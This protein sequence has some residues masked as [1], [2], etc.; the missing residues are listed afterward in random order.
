MLTPRLGVH[1]CDAGRPPSH[2]TRGVPRTIHFLLDGGVQIRELRGY[3]TKDDLKRELQ[4]FA[5]KDDLNDLRRTMLAL[6]RETS[7]QI[8]ELRRDLMYIVDNHE[9]RLNDLEAVRR[10]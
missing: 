5:T 4:R 8:R 6:H 7:D 10:V 3:A 1:S 9:R 2:S